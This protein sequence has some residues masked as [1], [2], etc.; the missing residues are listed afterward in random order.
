[1][2]KLDVSFGRILIISSEGRVH[3][4]TET[5][6]WVRTK[7]QM[8]LIQTTGTDKRPGISKI[9][10]LTPKDTAEGRLPSYDYS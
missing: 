3:S 10:R 2:K 6:D 9:H 8:T 1:M 4:E 7:P 5:V